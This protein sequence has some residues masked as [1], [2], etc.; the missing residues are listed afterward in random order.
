MRTLFFRTLILP[1][2]QKYFFVLGAAAQGWKIT[3]L[4]GNQFSFKKRLGDTIDSSTQFIQKYCHPALS[5]IHNL[6]S[7]HNPEQH[8]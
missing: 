5:Q 3:Y 1:F 6:F 4:G 8:E 7:I 2:L